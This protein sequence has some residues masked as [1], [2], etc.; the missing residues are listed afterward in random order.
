MLLGPTPKKKAEQ[1]KGR[2]LAGLWSIKVSAHPVVSPGAGMIS[3]LFLIRAGGAENFYPHIDGSFGMWVTLEGSVVFV[4]RGN[5]QRG[6]TA[7]L[8]AA[9]CQHF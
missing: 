6:L 4:S 8:R 7:E 2:S 5:P 9:F 1:D 3:R